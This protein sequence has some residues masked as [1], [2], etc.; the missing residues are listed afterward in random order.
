M[1]AQ[2]TV[3]MA[4][5][6]VSKEISPGI[7]LHRKVVNASLQV[8]EIQN[9]KT[10]ILE[11]TIDC[12]G[13]RGVTIRETGTLIR[14]IQ[15]VPGACLVLA[16]IVTE[17]DWR[18]TQKFKF[19]SKPPP[20]E[21]VQGQIDASY[22]EIPAKAK[23]CFEMISS[24]AVNTLRPR[25]IR[26][27]VGHFVDPH[28]LPGDNS[29]FLGSE[30]TR[31]DTAIHWRRPLEFM[32][33][34]YSVFH[35]EIEPN[36]IKQGKLGDCW[37]MCALSSLAERP[38]LVRRLFLIDEAN[39]EGIYRVKFCKDGEWVTVTIDD[40]LPCFPFGGP[41]F[42]RSQGNELWVLLLEKAYAKIHG[43]Y[44]LLRG[45]WAAEG[46]SDLTGCPTENLEFSSDEVKRQI[47]LNELW[48]Y[49]KNC[50]DNGAL[51][52]A[53][54]AG[55]DRWSE[56]G[57]PDKQGGLVPG[58]AY[59]LIAVK[60]AHG[61]RL[62][63]IRN[64]W[65]TFEWNGNWGDTSPLWNPRMR[66]ALK[67]TL[68]ANDG[69]FWMSFEDFLKNFS[70]VNICHVGTYHEARMKGLFKKEVLD[71]QSRV[72]A[73]WYYTVTAERPTKVFVGLHQNDERMLGVE[74]TR[75]YLDLGITIVVRE[76]DGRLSLIRYE[77]S[78]NARQVEC[79]VTFQPGHTYI[80]L[81]RT[82]GCAMQRQ[83]T[84]PVNPVTLLH[85]DQLNPLY[86][87]TIIDI[88]RKAN[89]VLG[90]DLSPQEFGSL[91]SE[92]GLSLSTETVSEIFRKYVS[93]EHGLTLDGFLHYM[94][95]TTKQV[96]E[97]RIFEWL[98]AWGY[99]PDLFSTGSRH[100]ILTLHSEDKLG[101]RMHKAKGTALSQRVDELILQHHGVKKSRIGTLDL[102]CLY[103]AKAN[104]FTYGVFNSADRRVSC[105]FDCSQSSG[106]IYG[107]GAARTQH[108]IEPNSWEILNYLQISKESENCRIRPQLRITG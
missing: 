4:E 30:Q 49:L 6:K 66:E 72:T 29:V 48:P 78:A 86:V 19:V 21:Q 74:K 14:T 41:I 8:L 91:F 71:S 9:N 54:T 2:P 107:T 5:Q 50:D 27:S 82:S 70:G 43:S 63:N 36:D 24:K 104:A 89:V 38:E 79:V 37:F 42:S 106:V 45:G 98:R 68:T 81:P 83:S 105:E 51:M 35:G 7:V 44:M 97:S 39:A 108:T 73:Q 20:R 52:S 101:V 33:G 46:M 90:D 80:I 55:E 22:S 100:F 58:H 47:S 17:G 57:G 10:D 84:T 92:V 103:E 99:E 67:P 60:E 26:R 65:G 53:S 94:H 62:V 18:M 34:T 25:D 85:G 31:L 1:A 69:T 59:T 87:S 93:S 96:G 95:D 16:S 11:F 64:P 15:I 102:Y 13:S 77:K 56:T 23:Q 3:I 40:Y 61:H 32:T 75:G 88:F 12:T 28:F 76:P